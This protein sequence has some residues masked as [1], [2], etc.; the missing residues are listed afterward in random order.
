MIQRLLSS[1]LL[2]AAS[3]SGFLFHAALAQVPTSQLRAG[4]LARME[5]ER[6]N[7]GL[8]VYSTANCMYKSGGGKC[9]VSDTAAGYRFKIPGGPPGWQAM[10]QEPTL[11][12]ELLISPDGTQVS[13]VTYNG[14]IR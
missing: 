9:M 10:G 13:D 11:E 12:T 4:N 2:V 8:S 7:G 14:S 5:A 3:C 1:S 6:L